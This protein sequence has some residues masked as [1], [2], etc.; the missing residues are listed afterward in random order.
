MHKKSSRKYNCI[1]RVLIIALI[2]LSTA[3]CDNGGETTEVIE[4]DDVIPE[5]SRN[6]D[7]NDTTPEEKTEEDPFLKN[8]RVAMQGEV[9]V[10]SDKKPTMNGTWKYIPD[11]L[12]TDSSFSRYFAVDSARMHFK[13]WQFEDSLRSINALYNWL[14][15]FGA[16]CSGVSVGDVVNVSPHSFLLLQDNLHIYIIQ[17]PIMI[18]EHQ[19][20]EFIEHDKKNTSWNYILFQSPGGKI[21][22]KEQPD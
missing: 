9:E 8:L 14:D 22:W 18:N 7:Y 3:Q 12:Q 11:R 17:S 10:L 1:F 15:C 5:A 6:Y 13:M 21:Q 2:A 19:W 4:M 20:I 16:N